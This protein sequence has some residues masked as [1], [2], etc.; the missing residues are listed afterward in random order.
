MNHIPF[1]RIEKLSEEDKFHAPR[2]YTE[3]FLAEACEELTPTTP[4]QHIFPLNG[5]DSP[6]DRD[7]FV[8]Q[9]LVEYPNY[10][11]ARSPPVY[12][13]RP[14]GA[15]VVD[16][17]WVGLQLCGPIV[18]GLNDIVFLCAVVR[19]WPMAIISNG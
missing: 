11:I 1:L 19:F 7:A 4:Q 8:V 10:F 12:V 18:V 6:V 16:G 13:E 5:K 3:H 9:R 2:D 14:P 17:D 15:A